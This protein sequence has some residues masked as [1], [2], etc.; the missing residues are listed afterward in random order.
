[1][2]RIDGNAHY[3]EV[4]ALLTQGRHVC[5][6]D[7]YGTALTLYT[8]LKR[9]VERRAPAVDYR[10]SRIQRELL[11]RLT[12]PLVVPIVDGQVALRG[13]PPIPF[14]QRLYPG[15]GAFYL[16]LPDVLGL[17]GAWQ[18][19]E[20]GVRYPVLAHPLHP[21]Y[22]AHF[23]TRREHLELFDSYLASRPAAPDRAVDVG[24]GAGA[25]TFLL[26]K[27]GAQHVHAVDA[28]PNAVLSLTEDVARLDLGGRVTVEQADLFGSAAPAELVVFNPPW[29]PGRQ[30]SVVDASV[31]HDAAIFPRFFAAARE[32]LQPGGRLVVLFSNFAEVA[33]LSQ[34]SPVAAEVDGGGR[35]RLVER[36][37]RGVSA[38]APRRGRDWLAQ[39]RGR[40]RVQVWVL[41]ST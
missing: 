23:S 1:M 33:G 18:W 13:A 29:V 31:Y 40:E 28:S 21:F 19:Y 2:R 24:A 37:E 6:T 27:H 32:R 25:L 39:V 11:W 34:V 22:G 41:E 14:L 20:R 3:R 30:Q 8:W 12:H 4:E 35:F 26:C 7:T 17:N 9:G 15:S 38:P 16:P 5:V 10:T 36:L